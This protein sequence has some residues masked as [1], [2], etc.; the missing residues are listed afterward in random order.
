M[1][2]RS[3]ILKLNDFFVL[4]FVRRNLIGQFSGIDNESMVCRTKLLKLLG[5]TAHIESPHNL[6]EILKSDR[7]GHFVTFLR[8]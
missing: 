1:N 7:P 8:N 2:A 5:V 4:V 3:Y 6:I